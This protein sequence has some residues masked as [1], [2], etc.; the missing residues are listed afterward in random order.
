M[1]SL[2]II[3][4]SVT[5]AA[6]TIALIILLIRLHRINSKADT[7]SLAD[8][9]GPD[10]ADGNAAERHTAMADSNQNSTTGAMRSGTDVEADR[11]ALTVEFLTLHA[12]A[13]EKF[14]GT[15]STVRRKLKA[16]QTAEINTMLEKQTLLEDHTKSFNQ[17]FDRTI[18]NLYPDFIEQVNS[19]L[20]PDKRIEAPD[21]GHLTTELRVLAFTCI[22]ID[23]T[24]M[25]ARFLRLSHNTIYTYRNRMRAR[26]IDRDTFDESI[27]HIVSVRKKP[28]RQ[29][30]VGFFRTDTPHPGMEIPQAGE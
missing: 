24:A 26:A 13:L 12:D 7:D 20:H 28:T 6:L 18:F 30:Q 10:A 2:T 19:L 1:P 15:L 17:T 16:G 4:N 3:V 11:R 21:E 9:D 22:G 8:A 5:I 27:Q 14:D 29:N 25:I 23:D